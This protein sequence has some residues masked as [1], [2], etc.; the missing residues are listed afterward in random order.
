RS[1]CGRDRAQKLSLP[2]FGCGWRARG[3]DVQLIGYG[4][5]QPPESGSLPRPRAGAH[6]RASRQPHR[7]PPTLERHA[8]SA[9]STAAGARQDGTDR[10]VTLRLQDAGSML[11]FTAVDRHSGD[12]VGMTTPMNI[13][14]ASPRV[15]I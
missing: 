10:A 15:E 7:R 13:D 3:H 5:T 1:A 12:I 11:P 9:T 6:R 2:G 8:L 4:E 14:A